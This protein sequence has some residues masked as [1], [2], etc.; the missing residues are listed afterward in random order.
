MLW[1]AQIKIHQV[2]STPVAR[3]DF[4]GFPADVY[5]FAILLW[6]VCSLGKAYAGMSKQEHLEM[7]VGA[8]V[9]PKLSSLE[10]SSGVKKLIHSCWRHDPNRRPKFRG[11]LIK[12]CSEMVL[13]N[14]PHGSFNRDH[15][16]RLRKH[17]GGS[18][19]KKLTMSLPSAFE[20]TD[21][22]NAD[23]SP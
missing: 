5:S 19:D 9:R 12:L 11:I 6:E 13:G 14:A 16:T 10:T 20:S 3:S 21:I 23:R 1:L 7:V 22:L 2:Q 4:Y 18:I 8:Q 15:T 17:R